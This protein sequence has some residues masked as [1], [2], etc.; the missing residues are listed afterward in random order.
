MKR[1]LSMLVVA[2]LVFGCAL[3]GCG[4]QPATVPEGPADGPAESIAEEPSGES[5]GLSVYLVQSDALYADAIACFQ[6]Q[7]PDTPLNVTAFH[8]YDA[9]IAA[10]DEELP[11]GG[12]PD[13]VL[14][15]SMEC[16][17]DGYQLAKSGAFLPLDNFVKELDPAIYP[18]ALMD[19]GSLAGKQYFIPFSYNL[20]YAYTSERRMGEMGRSPSDDLYGMILGEAEALKE[21]PDK[22]PTERYVYRPDPVNSFF[23]AA[24][25]RFF[26]KTSGEVAVDK[27]ALEEICR[28]VKIFYDEA[29]TTQ[30]LYA[31]YDQFNRNFEGAAQHFSFFTE[32]VSFLDMVRYYQSVFAEKVDSPMIALPYH[33]LSH[34]QEF[35]ASIVCF[36]GVNANTKMPEQAYGLLKYILDYDISSGWAENEAVSSYYA[37]VNLALFQ[38][39]VDKLCRTHGYGPVSVAPLSEENGARLKA[40][41][42]KI[43]D[44]VIPNGDLGLRLQEVLEPYFMGRSSFGDCYDT[45]F[46]ELQHYLNE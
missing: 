24:G 42:G 46:K 40:T 29:E 10:L 8:S 25:I 20:I 37:P 27:A 26:D 21:V 28:F 17:V 23:D 41:A 43:T 35:C 15:N 1:Y 16:V 11:L 45:L 4:Q 30:R 36:G 44:A 2:I 33:K 22:V 32:D 13:V 3:C 31:Q 34:P 14:Y 5:G 38:K 12:G 9:M 19:A 39:A 6:E 18:T 7:R